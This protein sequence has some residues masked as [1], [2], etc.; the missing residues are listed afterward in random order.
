MGDRTYCRTQIHKHYF[1]QHKKELQDIAN[2]NYFEIDDSD[3]DIVFFSDDQ[4]NYGDM[5]EL[6]KFLS[7]KRIEYDKRWEDG[8][9]YGAG[10]EFARNVQGEYKVF[11]ISDV[12][13]E[14]LQVH[15]NVKEIIDK[16]GSLEDVRE[17]VEK[18]INHIEPFEI[19]T[20]TLP[21]SIDFITKE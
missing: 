2:K 8:S 16:G 7:E 21:N 3:S 13:V 9:D 5:P 17:Y 20:L 12:G 10:E 15:L 14:I 4:A 19:T 6:V 11:D 18:E 1:Q